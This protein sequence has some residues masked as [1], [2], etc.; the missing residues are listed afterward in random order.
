MFG[1][2]LMSISGS[3]GIL[4]LLLVKSIKLVFLPEAGRG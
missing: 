3:E 2:V 1:S 4:D